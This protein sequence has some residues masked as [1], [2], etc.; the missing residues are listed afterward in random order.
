[1]TP[2]P[3][4]W[5]ESGTLTCTF[6]GGYS[7]LVRTDPLWILVITAKQGHEAPLETMRIRTA[8]GA[9]Y[10]PSEILTLACRPDRQ[11]D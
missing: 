6:A 8:S 10:G 7:Y 3:I 2:E 1:M 4:D 11:W 5:D 9:E